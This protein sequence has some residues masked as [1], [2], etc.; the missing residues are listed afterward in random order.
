MNWQ[1]QHVIVAG[2]AGFVGGHLVRA[3]LQRGAR[4]TVLDNFHTGMRDRFAGVSNARLKIVEHDVCAPIDLSCDLIIN[5]ACPASPKKYQAAPLETWRTSIFGAV[6]LSELAL[7][8]GARFVQASTSEVYGDPLEHPQ[9]ESYCGNVSFTGPRACYDEG[10]RAAETYLMDLHREVGLDLRIARIFNTYGPGMALD[11][12]RVVSN[13]VV[14]ALSGRVLT[15]YGDGLQ[16]RSFCYVSDTVDGLLALAETDDCADK[17]F[18]I[19]N[20]KEQS[21][22]DLA[23]LVA[24]MTKQDLSVQNGPAAGDDPRRRC[25]DISRA[26]A[27]LGWSPKVSLEEGL[28][29]TLAE[30]RGRLS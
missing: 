17:I 13:F 1:D 12:G 29:S 27:I 30:F 7:R 24:E 28:R 19:G 10:K 20:P 5:L 18:N 3:V 8:Q 4:V 22:L 16:T 23:N 2:G 25:P 11:D 9:R 21:V 14:Q 6:H 26:R 15:I